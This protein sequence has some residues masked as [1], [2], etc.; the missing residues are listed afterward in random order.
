LVD[1]GKIVITTILERTK[2]RRKSPQ[3]AALRELLTRPWFGRLW[4]IQE[5]VL[6]TDLLFFWGEH[7]LS[8]PELEKIVEWDI[9]ANLAV[10]L[11]RAA[12]TW[13]CLS[14]IRKISTL[15]ANRRGASKGWRCDLSFALYQ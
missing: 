1:Y 5:A 8:W 10:L 2:T 13:N 14:S 9:R 11:E 7:S 12:K 15:R 3:W 4:V 6:P